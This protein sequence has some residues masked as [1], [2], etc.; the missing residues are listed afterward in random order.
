[1]V[2]ALSPVIVE[3]IEIIATAILLAAVYIVILVVE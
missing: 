1:M 2:A 3:S